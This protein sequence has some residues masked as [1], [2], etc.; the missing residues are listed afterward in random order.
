VQEPVPPYGED[1]EPTGGP[2]D[3]FEP[4]GP[5]ERRK[6]F[7]VAGQPVNMIGERVQFLGPDGKL[8]TESLTDYTKQCVQKQFATLKDFFRHW[9]SAERKQEIIQQLAEQGVFWDELRAEVKQKHGGELDAFDLIAHIV[10]DAPPLT[11]RERANNVKKR[12]YFTKYQGAALQVL[13]N[14]LEKYA[15]TGIAHIE[16]IKIL[17][18]PPFNTMGTMVELVNAFGGKAGYEQA[19]HE[20]E[21]ALYDDKSIA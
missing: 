21:Q 19:L 18:L 8:I 15:D 9:S 4:T 5:G 7:F 11:R 2:E 14:L 3:I 16:D 1:G 6:K 20:L 17:Q 13:E 12:N 10:Y